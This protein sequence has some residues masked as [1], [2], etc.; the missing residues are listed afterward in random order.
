MSTLSNP[1]SYAHLA[2]IHSN[3]GNDF[4]FFAAMRN[5]PIA[6][7]KGGCTLAQVLNPT[8]PAWTE[9]FL[10]TNPTAKRD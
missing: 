8:S 6:Y 5:N 10:V 4:S 9:T 2:L 3:A 7:A 1:I